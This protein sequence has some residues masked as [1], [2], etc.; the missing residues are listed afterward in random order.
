MSAGGGH[1]VAHSRRPGTHTTQVGVGVGGCMCVCVCA[2]VCCARV[3]VCTCVCVCVRV[4]LCVCAV[5]VHACVCVCVCTC[6]CYTAPL[7]KA[8]LLPSLPTLPC[9]YYLVGMGGSLEDVLKA[10]EIVDVEQVGY[11]LIWGLEGARVTGGGAGSCA[12]TIRKG[13]DDW[14]T[15]HHHPLHINLA[16]PLS[17]TTLLT[18]P[19][20]APPHVSSPHSPLISLGHHATPHHT[21]ASHSPPGEHVGHLTVPHLPSP[22]Q[23][24]LQI[25]TT[26]QKLIQPLT[27]KYKPQA[28]LQ[29][30]GGGG[31]GPLC[32]GPQVKGGGARGPLCVGPQVKLQ[33]GGGGG[34]RTAVCRASSQA[35]GRGR[36]PLCLGLGRQA[37]YPLLPLPPPLTRTY[38]HTCSH[39]IAANADGAAACGHPHRACPLRHFPPTLFL[40]P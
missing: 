34:A 39:S 28:K 33:V 18:P 23:V 31:R 19:Y 25:N 6:V 40:P 27:D 20:T 2:C 12:C 7:P 14:H 26:D 11:F 5:C 1:R 13:G 38:T 9:S 35:A 3:C 29:V 32:V 36:R 4:C 16:H 15:H 37:G 17:L 22:L 21:H 24:R 10:A 8:P 30:G